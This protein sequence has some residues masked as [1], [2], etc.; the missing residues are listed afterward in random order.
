MRSSLLVWL[1]VA[2]AMVCVAGCGG[3]RAARPALA[4]LDRPTGPARSFLEPHDLRIAVDHRTLRM[5]PFAP[6]IDAL[7]RSSGLLQRLVGGT[8]G[9]G[10]AGLDPLRDVDLVAASTHVA[11]WSA[12]GVVAERWRLVLRHRLTEADVLGRL[13]R[14]AL[15]HGD[16]LRWRHSQGLRSGLLPSDL[17]RGVPHVVL[18][19]ALSELVIVPEDEL[20]DAA[21]TARDHLLRR[22]RPE[23]LIEPALA[24]FDQDDGVPGVLLELDGTTL[25]QVLET[26]GAISVHGTAVWT[27][28]RVEVQV[29]LS[30]ADASG[31]SSAA[32]A[33]AAQLAGFRGNSPVLTSL[34]IAGWVDRLAFT[35]NGSDL[36]VGTSGDALEAGALCRAIGLV[37]A[38]S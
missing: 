14:G 5:L 20:A 15:A 22:S 1:L 35:A 38:I 7:Y 33:L 11:A 6:D 3:T 2:A 31:A 37:F 8:L 19:S 32:A 36:M 34:G 29:V 10:P 9:G 12:R 17:S 26:M 25:P 18:L 13:E 30:F 23:Q 28:G 24:R 27:G 16:T 21:L 4:P